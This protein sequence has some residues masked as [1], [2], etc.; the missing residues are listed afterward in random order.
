MKKLLILLVT[1]TACGPK[2]QQ[3]APAPLYTPE[4]GRQEVRALLD[5]YRRN[6]EQKD[7]GAIMAAYSSDPLV[8]G[9]DAGEYLVGRAA[10][11]RGFRQTFDGIS[12]VQAEVLDRVIHTSPDGET[13]WSAERWNLRFMQGKVKKTLPGVRVTEVLRREPDGWRIVQGHASLGVP[14][15]RAA[16]PKRR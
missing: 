6:F 8:I 12:N 11:E 1:L 14:V 3:P 5:D 10:V 2:V 4:A 16:K 13:A 7:L 9:T 15:K